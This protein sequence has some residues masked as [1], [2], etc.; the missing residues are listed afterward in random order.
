MKSQ[1]KYRL[2]IVM[3]LFSRYLTG[4]LIS[5][6]VLADAQ[7]VTTSSSIQ[8]ASLSADRQWVVY[9]D[10]SRVYIARTSDLQVVD[11]WP[12]D[13]ARQG[14]ITQLAFTEGNPNVIRIQ[15][16]RWNGDFAPMDISVY[17][18]DSVILYHRGNKKRL[19]A[20]PG[21]MMVSYASASPRYTIVAN[22]F[23]KY[24][25]QGKENYG[26]QKGMLG[27][28]PENDRHP[29][30]K[31]AVRLA[32][33]AMGDKVAI[34]Y[35]D[36]LTKKGEPV[37]SVEVRSLR[38]FKLISSK[39]GL[40]EKP[41]VFGFSANGKHLI[42]KPQQESSNFDDQPLVVLNSNTLVVERLTER[43]S[44]NFPP[45]IDNSKVVEML[46]RGMKIQRRN[47]VSQAV[48]WTL[49]PR[50][51]GVYHKGVLP[52]D[53][54]Y[55][56]VFGDEMD[57]KGM[58]S[59]KGAIRKVDLT[60]LTIFTRNED[61]N[62]VDTIYRPT[63]VRIQENII[64]TEDFIVS[65][66]GRVLVG[67]NENQLEVWSAESR[68]KLMGYRFEN[69]IK[70]YPDRDGQFILILEKYVQ[71]SYS[72]F[73]V[74]VFDLKQGTLSTR[75]IQNEERGFMDPNYQ[76][77]CFAL[78]DKPASWICNDRGT[79]FWSLSRDNLFPTKLVSVDV[80]D[81]R[82]YS[83]KIDRISRTSDR[84]VLQF[85]LWRRL[86]TAEQYQWV[87]HSLLNCQTREVQK[88]EK[89]NLSP[90]YWQLSPDASIQVAGQ[91]LQFVSKGAKQKLLSG[92]DQFSFLDARIQGGRVAV[93]Y[94][95]GARADSVKGLVLNIQ[96]EKIEN[97]FTLPDFSSFTGRD[98]HYLSRENLYTWSVGSDR[99]VQWDKA[100][101]NP[102]SYKTLTQARD[103]QFD[104]H[105]LML[106]RGSVSLN[107]ADLQVRVVLPS[108]RFGG[109]LTGK[110]KGHLVYRVDSTYQR[111][112]GTYGSKLKYPFYH[113]VVASVNQPDNPVARS[114]M[115]RLDDGEGIGGDLL[116][117]N[118]GRY[119]AFRLE[120]YT[121]KGKNHRLNLLDIETMKVT[122]LTREEA[123]SVIF[124]PDD[125]YLVWGVV[126]EP[127]NILAEL[128]HTRY[129]ISTGKKRP[130]QTNKFDGFTKQHDQVLQAV[131]G[132][133]VIGRQSGDS[134]QRVRFLNSRQFMTCAAYLTEH[135]LVAG[136]SD[137]GTVFFW[138]P[139]KPSPLGKVACGA[140]GILKMVETHNRL[141]VL[142]ANMRL[143]VIDLSSR[144]L[145][146]TGHYQENEAG[147]VSIS[148]FTPEGYYWVARDEVRRYHFVRE[149]RAFS[150]SSYELK[151]N[152]PDIIL[153]RTGFSSPE[154]VASYLE[155]YRRRVA[156]YPSY[157]EK[158]EWEATLPGLQIENKNQLKALTQ[159][160]ECTLNVYAKSGN[161]PLRTVFVYVNGNPVNGRQGIPAG[162][163]TEFRKSI[164]FPLS[165]GSNSIRVVVEDEAGVESFP[166]S[167]EVE[168]Q[169][170]YTPKVYFVGIGVSRYQ[171]ASMN[172]KY[173]DADVRR[174]AGDFGWR[175]GDRL[176]VDTL[177][178]ER[179]TVENLLALREKLK[180][181]HVDDYVIVSFSG[182]GLLDKDMNFFFACHDMDFKNPEKRGFSYAQMESL[183]D[184][185]PARRKLLLIDACHSGEVDQQQEASAT[186]SLAPSVQVYQTK[187]ATAEIVS[188]NTSS[189]RL[190]QSL[191]SDVTHSNGTFVISASS[192]DEFA[193]ES[194][195]W[196][197]GV[198][199][200]SF[201]HA[202]DDL[203]ADTR[204]KETFRISTLRN[205]VYETVIRLTQN[206]QR[207]TSRAENV[208]WNWR[209][210]DMQ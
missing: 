81:T 36:S 171:D 117:S 136:G 195:A 160:P 120:G 89:P 66:D 94:R 191:F 63:D 58:Y 128:R 41:T 143:A 100:D 101:F 90:V 91:E 206:R 76:C 163:V 86:W 201:L 175:Y 157:A 148:W 52:L 118:T 114:S 4:L 131:N 83:Y 17:P 159:D 126:K 209:F 140:G 25:Y 183:T 150:L 208:D 96:T 182:H 134:V 71:R 95:A 176:V 67:T 27:V 87:G 165:S 54:Q 108:Y 38:D 13:V 68:K 121:G 110:L 88:I 200:Y 115:I 113:M 154:L 55:L 185:I 93:F 15:Y 166:E 109:L 203:Y 26:A 133:V 205:K 29:L 193:F 151:L 197:G 62:R 105:E 46:D 92:I 45:F 106:L 18:A 44:V 16:S 107:L 60:E 137:Q 122:T 33:S 198:F 50:L 6:S 22:E 132:G 5:Y 82:T 158:A 162:S 59:G 177:L 144:K 192:G 180:T 111:I 9:A 127:E 32:L 51:T 98:V 103:L 84:D 1:L 152:R 69:G 196:R 170:E 7:V 14:R 28:F 37:Y 19:G 179:V 73:K 146:L 64:L 119:V 2:L 123:A 24:N 202:L 57:E 31:V 141:F 135:N 124:S 42:V 20:L 77:D 174:L 155:A 130:L 190:M 210:I 147:E 8:M 99:P 43:D 139:E 129:E 40:T 173:A 79:S 85:Q 78:P 35:F 189:F 149:A 97:R 102:E 181:T 39:H 65:D 56:I 187:G 194:D 112:D 11:Q 188:Q 199:T 104:N 116:V 164:S 12:Y 161:S 34:C 53:E 61:V 80:T 23:F 72:E 3:N 125:Q 74:H 70:A 184:L 48:E 186:Q 204:G 47:L 10:Q 138:D 142:M 30:A 172:L 21:N 75:V 49:W 145:A 169:R 207:P 167:V 178:N 168:L 153:S 156:R